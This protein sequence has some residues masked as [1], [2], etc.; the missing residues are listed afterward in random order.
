MGSSPRQHR[1]RDPRPVACPDRFTQAGWA[2]ALMRYRILQLA[3]GELTPSHSLRIPEE[4]AADVREV[5]R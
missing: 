5:H 3:Q 4:V 1:I 2:N